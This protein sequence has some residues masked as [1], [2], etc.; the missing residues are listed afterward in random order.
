MR[1]YTRKQ[2]EKNNTSAL[3]CSA[4]ADKVFNRSSRVDLRLEYDLRVMNAFF[5]KAPGEKA[6]FKLVGIQGNRGPAGPQ[7]DLPSWSYAW[8]D[9]DGTTPYWMSKLTLSQILPQIIIC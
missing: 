4:E 7:I 3:T 2:R 9:I 1:N 8:S 5:Q 6:T